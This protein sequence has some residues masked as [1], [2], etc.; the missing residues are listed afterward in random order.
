M[1]S[2]NDNQ[3]N[4]D[5]EDKKKEPTDTLNLKKPLIAGRSRTTMQMKKKLAPTSSEKDDQDS[6]RY[7]ISANMSNSDILNLQDLQNSVDKSSYAVTATPATAGQYHAHPFAEEAKEDDLEEATLLEYLAGMPKVSKKS[8]DYS[9][10]TLFAK[11]AKV[12]QQDQEANTLHEIP[13]VPQNDNHSS[14]VFVAEHSSIVPAQEA[15]APPPPQQALPGAF[16]VQGLGTSSQNYSFVNGNVDFDTN[17]I[18]SEHDQLERATL[19]NAE[20]VVD[21]E[22]ASASVV[23]IEAEKRAQCKR[24]V[25]TALVL[26]LVDKSH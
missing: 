4:D 19:F 7:P 14:G 12:E 2:N 17:E 3:K 8:V 23:D 15:V 18:R 13:V 25:L 20:L 6:S 10:E 21:P 5:G 26:F 9:N 1:S 16:P 22:L 24:Q 11:A